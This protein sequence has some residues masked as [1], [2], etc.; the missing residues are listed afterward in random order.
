VRPARVAI[1]V[2]TGIFA[3]LF[4]AKF[5]AVV[6]EAG[7]DGR[8]G[9]DFGVYVAIARQFFETGSLY[10]PFQLTGPYPEV[11]YAD[12][13]VIN[14]YPPPMLLLFAPFTIL[15]AF[16]W[17]A[18][19]LGIFGAMT[20]YWRPAPWSWPILVGSLALLPFAISI[21]MGNTVLW[22]MAITALATRWPGAAVGLA[23]KPL[24][25]PFALPF[26][27]RSRSWLVGL[28]VAAVLAVAFLP[29]W[30]D[31]VSAMRNEVTGLGI[32]GSF[33]YFFPAPFLALV[34]VIPWLART[35]RAA[36]LS[37]DARGAPAARR[38]PIAEKPPPI[39]ET[40]AAAGG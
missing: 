14:L 37:P 39:G 25:L 18:I 10:A 32:V 20:W 31:Y 19:P 12:G 21:L 16:L 22:A 33:F 2:V 36:Q 29:W 17:W 28:A 11:I 23:G 40:P 34:P 26:L 9:Y 4:V 30:P 38:A 15:P 8:L 13:W 5:I 35:R 7:P 3:L 27:R 24:L 6:Q 1:G